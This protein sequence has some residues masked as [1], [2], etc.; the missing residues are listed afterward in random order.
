VA[1]PLSGVVSGLL[2]G[3]IWKRKLP[4]SYAPTLSHSDGEYAC[5]DAGV[6]FGEKTGQ[7][8]QRRRPAAMPGEQAAKTHRANALGL[9]DAP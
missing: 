1:V 2:N 3:D 9:G 6:A 5:L 4:G 8:L 7:S